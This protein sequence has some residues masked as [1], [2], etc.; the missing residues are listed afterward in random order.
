MSS[1]GRGT[2]LFSG[3]GH[4]L[5]AHGKFNKHELKIHHQTAAVNSPWLA[6]LRERLVV[7]AVTLVPPV[8]AMGWHTHPITPSLLYIFPRV[9]HPHPALSRTCGL[10]SQLSGTSEDERPPERFHSCCSVYCYVP[11]AFKAELAPV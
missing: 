10:T 3:A 9:R 1:W 11:S 2:A 8:P 5:V 6:G 4:V 7:A